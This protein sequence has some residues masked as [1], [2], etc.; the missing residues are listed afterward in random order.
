MSFISFTEAGATDNPCDEIYAGPSA[1]SEPEI[2][3][4]QNYVSPFP[5]DYFKVYISL[6]SYGQYILSPWGHT[7]DEFP[8][9]YDDM[10]GVAKGFADALYRRYKTVF[11][12][13]S[14]STVLCESYLFFYVYALQLTIFSSL[15]R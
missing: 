1:N 7:S 14:S 3:H 11:T 12:Y 4:V 2:Q 9:N 5:E 6:H 8:D 10:L 13:G 15:F